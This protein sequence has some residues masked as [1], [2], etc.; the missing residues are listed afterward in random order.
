M[1][2]IKQLSWSGTG[3]SLFHFR[4]SSGQEVD[5]VVEDR[6]GG[7][8]GIE[9]KSSAKVDKKD[10]SGLR[11]LAEMTGERFRQGC[12]LYRGNEVVPFGRDLYAVPVEY[13]WG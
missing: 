2:L 9:V 7:L 10:L 13:L 1:E 11:L 8:V 6:S 4:I 3:S 12:V 5:L